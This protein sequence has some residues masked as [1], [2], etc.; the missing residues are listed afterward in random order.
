MKTARNH[1]SFAIAAV[2][3]ALA[4]CG[5]ILGLDDFTNGSA[6]AT[7]TGGGAST[8]TATGT[9]GASATGVGGSAGAGGTSC[10]PNATE[11]CYGGPPTT[12]DVGACRG[13]THI[14]N[15]QGTAFGECSGEIRPSTEDCTKAPD[16]DCDGQACSQ[17]IWAKRFLSTEI[18]VTGGV[19]VDP[20]GNIVLTGVFLGTLTL[21]GQAPL[22]SVGSGDAFLAKFDSTGKH[23]WSKS[24]GN[25]TFSQSAIAVATSAAGDIAVTGRMEGSL[26]FGGSTLV[27]VGETDVFVAK[28]DAAGNHVWSKRFGDASSQQALGMAF[29]SAG[30]VLVTGQFYGSI[31][32][33][34]GPLSNPDG[35]NTDLFVAKLAS[36]TGMSLW[37][38]QF[39]DPN[40]SEGFGLGSLIATD[41]NDNVILAGGFS[42]TISFGG[43]APL[44]SQGGPDVYVAKLDALGDHIWSKRYGDVAGQVARSLSIT[45]S[46]EI[47]IAGGYGGTINFG[48]DLTAPMGTTSLFLAKIDASGASVWGRGFNSVVMPWID[49]SPDD[50]IALAATCASAGLD[51]GGGDLGVPGSGLCIAKY[52]PTGNHLWSRMLPGSADEQK[53]WSLAVDPTSNAIIISGA[54]GATIDFGT[55]PLNGPPLTDIFLAKIAP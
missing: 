43:A 38:K 24:F 16:E 29:D 4:G 12:E 11:H 27:T 48:T 10:T 25:S 46:N 28:F 45:K 35:V 22:T 32:F 34:N 5:T 51:L 14:C 15:A 36:S 54:P 31:D 18:A 44:V 8:T 23:I 30:N 33:G 55:G 6:S 17:A 50:D 37:S 2:P 39:G 19:D 21:D 20:S 47:L 40:A 26:N 3:F 49:V 1:V 53:T 42:T 41:S 52:D 9:A 7:G 13:G